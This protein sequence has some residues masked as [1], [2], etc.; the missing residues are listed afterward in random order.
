MFNGVFEGNDFFFTIFGHLLIMHIYW[1]FGVGEKNNQSEKLGNEYLSNK[2]LMKWV[3]F[4]FSVFEKSV[5][6]TWEE[7]FIA[8]EN[9]RKIKHLFLITHNMHIVS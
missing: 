8:S 1:K 4:S 6:S 5:V 7:E 9:A 3:S 2:F